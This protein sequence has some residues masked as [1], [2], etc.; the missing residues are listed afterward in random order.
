MALVKVGGKGVMVT[1]TEGA[2]INKNKPKK[3]VLAEEKYTEDMEKIIER[4]FFPDMEK[5]RVQ[6][7]YIDA[8][9]NKDTEKMRELAIRLSSTRHKRPHTITE[10]TDTYAS[11][12]TFETPD[13]AL[14]GKRS[15]PRRQDLLI[16]LEDNDNEVV[17]K[18]KKPDESNRSLDEYLAR[19][20]SEDN[21]SFCEIMHMA[22]EKQ[23]QKHEWMYNAE[24]TQKEEQLKMIEGSPRLAIKGINK[25][26]DT[27]TY[28]AKNQLM[29][30]PEGVD[31]SIDEKI[32]K[33][34]KHREIVHDNTRFQINPFNMDKQKETMA[35]AA[36]AKAVISLGKIGHDGKEILTEDTPKV[37]GYSMVAT[38][39]PAP[40]RDGDE[41]P[42]MTWGEIESTPFRL[43]GSETPSMGPTFRI[44]NFPR[45]EQLGITLAEKVSKSHRAKKGD[46]RKVLENFKTPAMKR[47][48]SVERMSMLSPAARKL[49]S[50]SIG[51]RGAT[52]KALRASYT[53]S[54][55]RSVGD[56]TPVRL[57]P[58]RL[59][60][61]RTPTT[62]SSSGIRKTPKI[63]SIGP[64]VSTL[65][66][67]LL[68]LPK[69]PSKSRA[70]A[71]DFF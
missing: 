41:S 71:T 6:K 65:T 17:N 48:G 40:G 70:K 53:P 66:D 67:N 30:V 5:M 7:E 33:Q 54:P 50:K 14:Q 2:V 47:M 8:M 3:K 11:P 9:E 58:V 16:D 26:V 20:T 15:S 22:E 49:V 38:P 43:D 57:T 45:R 60:P 61:H 23:K 62:T 63:S 64:D 32:N 31:E 59:T 10:N 24:Q 13:V 69:K 46:A 36:A 55:Q 44:A 12:S 51:N 39:S 34:H 68:N 19:N 1:Q 35:R 27:W 56:K 42:M 37:N 25:K 52:D 29:Y 18:K 4:D 28:Q 21:A